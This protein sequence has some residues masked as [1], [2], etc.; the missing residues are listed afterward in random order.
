MVADVCVCVCGGRE[1][2][3]EGGEGGSLARIASHMAI[4]DR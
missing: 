4:H 2:G 3:G 1:G